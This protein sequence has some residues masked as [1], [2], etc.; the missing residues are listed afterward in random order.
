MTWGLIFIAFYTIQWLSLRKYLNYLFD[1]LAKRTPTEDR[2]RALAWIR[3]LKGINYSLICLDWLGF[4]LY[5]LGR[6]PDT[7][8]NAFLRDF[9]SHLVALHAL[10]II[11]FDSSLSFIEIKRGKGKPKPDST[12]ST[13]PDPVAET[14]NEMDLSMVLPAMRMPEKDAPNTMDLSIIMADTQDFM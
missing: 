6:L 3:R 7:R 1:R 12:P 5:A 4:T 11:L 10:L 9:G 2:L 8:W 14:M 13:E